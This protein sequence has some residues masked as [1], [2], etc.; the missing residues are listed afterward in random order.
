MLPYYLLMAFPMLAYGVTFLI[1]KNKPFSKKLS[2][3][4]FFGAL[5]MVLAWRNITVGIDLP[6]YQYYFYKIHATPWFDLGNAAEIEFGYVVLNKIISDITANYFIF[7]AVVALITVLP[8]AFV[9]VNN[10]EHPD[11]SIVL[12]MNMST[13]ALM[14]SGLRQAIAISLG[15][16]AYHFLTKK[17]P[18][19]SAIIILLALTFHTSAFLLVL[20]FPLYYIKIGKKLMLFA[21]A[22]VYLLT[23]IFNKQILSLLINLLPEKYANYAIE[24][25][26]AYTMILVFAAF[27]LYASVVPDEG[28][29]TRELSALRNF[30]LLALG[31][32]LFAPVNTVAMRFNYYYII[33]IPLLLP[34][35]MESARDSLLVPVRLGKKSFK[36]GFSNMKL[37]VNISRIVIVVFFAAY[38]FF[39]AYTGDDILKIFPYEPCWI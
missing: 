2:M 23:L 11:V 13:F 8:V 25:T 17:K 1:F 26:G 18:W 36:I 34:K 31:V 35:V 15:V 5:F 9:F 16:L 3:A 19:L 28:K 33:F 24:S 37:W 6:G 30:L 27:L 14:F 20:M 22:P 7:L 39:D 4:C 12:F 32:Q 21:V 38:F 29:L 10:A